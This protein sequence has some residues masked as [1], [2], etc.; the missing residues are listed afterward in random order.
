MKK[1]KKS[2]FDIT[3][4]ECVEML[5]KA[6]WKN[7][8]FC[9]YC[10]SYEVV[11]NGTDDSTG[12][13]VQRY[14]CKHC[15][16]TFNVKTKTIF[17]NTKIPLRKWFIMFVL[18]DKNSILSISK[19]LDICY[20]TAYMMA[21]KIRFLISKEENRRIFYG[22]I[23]M[24]IDE[25]YVSSGSKGKINLD[26]QP[27]KRGLKA[28]KGRGSFEKDKPA[29]VTFVNRNTKETMFFVPE[30]LSGNMKKVGEQTTKSHQ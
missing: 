29:I 2:V 30:H 28:N 7:G 21:K 3:E 13:K 23:K 5:E 22:N 12:I 4:K 26:R 14:L 18:L 17:E 16:N 24:E 20:T 11:K 1:M 10:K 15:K 25:M 8:I 27:R 6:R 9:P 19:L